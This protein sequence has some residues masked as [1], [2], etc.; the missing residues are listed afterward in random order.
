[1]NTGTLFGVSLGPGD[2]GL[3]TRR[4][5]QRLSEARVWAYPVRRRGGEGFARAIAERAGIAPPAHEEPLVFPMTHDRRRLERYWRAAAETVVEHLRAGRDV[6]FLVEGDAST[7]STF[8]HLA[9]TVADI[10]PDVTIE[11]LPGVTAY[12]AAAARSGRPLA[13]TDD[14]V[15]IVPAAYGLEVIESLL[16]DFDCLVLLKVKP[17]LDGIIDLLERR[18][19]LDE[20]RFVEKLGAP[21]ERLV[22]AIAGL[23]GQRVNYLSL[24]IVRNPGRARGPLVRGCRARPNSVPSTPSPQEA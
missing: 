8:G 3:I 22:D 12:H 4:S 9:R 13:D 10:A 2:P 24:L 11:T 17:L 23:R 16:D 15:A 7:Y 21:G 19:L 18:G 1:M 20:T 5:W 14:T 6:D